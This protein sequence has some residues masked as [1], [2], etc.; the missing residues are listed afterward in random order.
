MPGFHLL[1]HC[2]RHCHRLRNLILWARWSFDI[3]TDTDKGAQEVDQQWIISGAKQCFRHL[4]KQKNCLPISFF[5]EQKKN[6]DQIPKNI[7]HLIVGHEA[8]K[9][10]LSNFCI[11]YLRL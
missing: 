5:L 10:A 2:L 9:S 7:T 6:I 8:P 11:R 3:D 1:L 4:K